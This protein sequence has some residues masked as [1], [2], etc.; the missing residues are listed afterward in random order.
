MA[1]LSGQASVDVL[2]GLASASLSLSAGLGFSLNI[3]PPPVQFNPS[4]PPNATSVTLGPETVTLLASCSV[5]IHLT[6][7]WVISVSWDG[8]WSFSQSIST[9]AITVGI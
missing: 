8:S 9:P 1:I 6:I 2:D 7:C 5:G 4:P 3:L